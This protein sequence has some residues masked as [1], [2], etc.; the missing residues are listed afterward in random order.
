MA[1]EW[2]WA[3]VRFSKLA[4]EKQGGDKTYTFRRAWFLSA[5]ESLPQSPMWFLFIAKAFS[6]HS[7]LKS[8]LTSNQSLPKASWSFGVRG[9]MG[10]MGHQWKNPAGESFNRINSA[11]DLVF[12]PQLIIQLLWAVLEAARGSCRQI[13][14]HQDGTEVPVSSAITATLT[15]RDALPIWL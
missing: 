7:F 5:K 4:S 13:E 6:L 10:T 8:L 11:A 1:E 12:G 15:N 2:K 9:K 14:L 3:K